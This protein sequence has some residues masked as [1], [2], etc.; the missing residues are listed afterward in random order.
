MSLFCKRALATVQG[1]RFKQQDGSV[2]SKVG[3]VPAKPRLDA[4]LDSQTRNGT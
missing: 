3:R 1:M 4:R 2:A